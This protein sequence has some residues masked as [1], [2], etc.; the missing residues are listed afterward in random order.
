MAPAPHIASC[1]VKTV[2]GG[3]PSIAADQVQAWKK[4]VT[5]K[6]QD[7]IL[8]FQVQEQLKQIRA[9]GESSPPALRRVEGLVEGQKRIGGLD[10]DALPSVDVL[11]NEVSEPIPLI[12]Q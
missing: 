7:Y 5:V 8:L 11:D 2:V 4:L 12:V 1:D 3:F 6:A 10:F 9:L